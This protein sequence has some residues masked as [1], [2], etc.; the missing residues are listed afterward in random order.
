MP[1]CHMCP[2][3]AVVVGGFVPKSVQKGAFTALG[4]PGGSLVL[5][6]P[7]SGSAAL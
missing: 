6:A 2:G 3:P 4:E 1:P 7:Y 5:F